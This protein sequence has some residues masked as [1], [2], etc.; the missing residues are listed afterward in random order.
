MRWDGSGSLKQ[1][2]MSIA[3]PHFPVRLFAPGPRGTC[4][5]QFPQNSGLRNGA[6]HLHRLTA[7]CRI[8]NEV[9]YRPGFVS[10]FYQQ[11]ID[12]GCI[13]CFVSPHGDHAILFY[14]PVGFGGVQGNCLVGFT[15]HS[16]VSSKIDQQCMAFGPV[17]V[18]GLSVEFYPWKFVGG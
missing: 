11:L 12:V 7:I 4:F 13:V 6:G 5:F 14:K 18:Q 16:P 15:S 3:D 9:W 10:K 8:D 2:V 17:L 1:S